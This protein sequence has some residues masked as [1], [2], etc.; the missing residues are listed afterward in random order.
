VHLRAS[1]TIIVKVI[2]EKIQLSTV[3]TI[4]DGARSSYG[5]GPMAKKNFGRG[6]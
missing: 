2:I 4:K 5:Q 1:L 3:T 6:Q